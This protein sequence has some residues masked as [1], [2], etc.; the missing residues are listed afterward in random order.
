MPQHTQ[1]AAACQRYHHTLL[2][3]LLHMLQP[4]CTY[5]LQQQSM[6]QSMLIGPT[7]TGSRQQ[8]SLSWLLQRVT[9]ATTAVHH[10][11]PPGVDHPTMR[12]MC[13]MHARQPFALSPRQLVKQ[14]PTF[15]HSD[16][17]HHNYHSK[18]CKHA[19]LAGVLPT[20]RQCHAHAQ[21]NLLSSRL[22]RQL[23]SVNKQQTT[24]T[25]SSETE[26]QHIHR[27][28]TVLHQTGSRMAS[29]KSPHRDHK[30]SSHAAAQHSPRSPKGKTVTAV[31]Q[32][33]AVA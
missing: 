32:S 28:H 11:H 9:H 31:D 30:K 23:L 29:G 24:F 6:Q 2:H 14:D 5:R 21:S 7:R 4:T 8:P 22:Q 18:G 10:C 33:A 16:L 15:R 3:K 25:T 20:D 19:C 17:N 13:C 1:T 12:F 27:Q 26:T